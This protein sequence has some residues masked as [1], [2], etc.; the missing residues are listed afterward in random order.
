[1]KHLYTVAAI[2]SSLERILETTIKDAKV[3]LHDVS[4]HVKALLIDDLTNHNGSHIT[5]YCRSEQ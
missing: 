1:M 5:F 4:W 2:S 3:P